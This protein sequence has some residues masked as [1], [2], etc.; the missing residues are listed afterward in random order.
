MSVKILTVESDK[1]SEGDEKG[2]H[3]AMGPI[4]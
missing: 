3:I 4:I 2:P 1:I